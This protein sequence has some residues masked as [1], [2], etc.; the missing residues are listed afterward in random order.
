MTDLA[1]NALGVCAKHASAPAVATCERCG[2]HVCEA[3]RAFYD[4]RA[5]C[6]TCL[7]RRS[8]QQPASRRAT[9]AMGLGVA[10]VVLM[11]LPFG[12][13]AALLGHTELAA[14]QAGRAP[15]GGKGYALAGIV[16][17]WL[18]VLFFLI[19]ALAV[20]VFVLAVWLEA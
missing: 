19:L 9:W 15:E 18:N 10:G 3:C 5:L 11:V 14:I 6:L 20:G 17:G 13:P 8:H 4:Y 16:L 12:V 1:S 2:S 7:E